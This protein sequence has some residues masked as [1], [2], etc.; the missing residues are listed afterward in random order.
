MVNTELTHHGVKGQKWYVR[1]FQNKDG[2][3]TNLGK[4]RKAS[5]GESV[6][7]K[8]TLSDEELKQRISRLELEKRYRELS[9]NSEQKKVSKG[10]T[11]VGEVLEKSGKNIATQLATYALG[12]A[13]N[14]FFGAEIVNPK[15][16]QK[17]K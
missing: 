3:L 8:N 17:D 11:F 10:R 9:G 6:N 14:K 4:K 16:G 5:S 1:R 12:T 2:S 13:V 7:E 15:K